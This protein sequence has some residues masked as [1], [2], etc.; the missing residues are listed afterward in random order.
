MPTIT[1]INHIRAPDTNAHKLKE[2]KQRNGRSGP[3]CR[4]VIRLH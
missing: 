2:K 1:N 3:R 4:S